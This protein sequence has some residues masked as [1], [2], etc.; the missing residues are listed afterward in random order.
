M[1]LSRLAYE[2]IAFTGTPILNKNGTKL[3]IRW[4]EANVKFKVTEEN[5][6]VA[7][8]A[9]IFYSPRTQVKEIE[10]DVGFALENEEY[11]QHENI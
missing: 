6:V 8:N 1:T 11:Q 9:M 3:L 4:L 2:T 5:F 7:T 10:V